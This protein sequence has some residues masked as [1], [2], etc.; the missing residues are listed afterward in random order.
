MFD[1]VLNIPV[2]Q[3]NIFV[4]IL[5]P[6]I[7]TVSP[8]Y[9]ET[10]DSIDKINK[11]LSWFLQIV[12]IRL[13]TFIYLLILLSWQ[14]FLPLEFVVNAG[15]SKSKCMHTYVPRGQNK[16]FTVPG[17]WTSPVAGFFQCIETACSFSRTI[18]SFDSYSFFNDMYFLIN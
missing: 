13:S 6:G 17:T 14:I 11:T 8:Q 2:M 10:F 7:Y 16:Q 3:N 4:F 9:L 5:Q 12:T 15:K 1:R 18:N